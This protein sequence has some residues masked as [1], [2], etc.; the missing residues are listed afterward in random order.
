[1]QPFVVMYIHI[2]M[3]H[4]FTIWTSFVVL[5]LIVQALKIKIFDGIGEWIPVVIKTDFFSW[6]TICIQNVKCIMFQMWWNVLNIFCCA[7]EFWTVLACSV[8]VQLEPEPRLQLCSLLVWCLVLLLL[9]I[10]SSY[11]RSVTADL[12]LSV[13]TM[14]YL[15]S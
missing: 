7:E 12:T 4:F 10:W 2:Y 1:M 15:L 8:I 6:S 9:S 13:L 11:W 3:F 14:F 5:L